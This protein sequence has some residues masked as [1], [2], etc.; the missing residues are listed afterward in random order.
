MPPR[1]ADAST[2]AGAGAALP[3]LPG[4]DGL[5][6]VA[7]VAV[8]LYHAGLSWIPGG[9]LG[10][11]VFFVISGYL[12]TSLLLAEHRR[13]GTVRLTAFW[14]RRARRLLPALFALLAVV[15]LCSLL[16]LPTEVARLRGDVIGALT[17]TANW[18]LV[19]SDQS[20]FETVG[21]PSPLQHLWSLAV[22]EQFYV[23]WPVLFSLGIAYW[24]RA[25]LLRAVAV[26]AVASSA[27]MW[28]LF[29]PGSDPSRAYYGSDTRASGLLVGAVLAFLWTPWRLRDRAGRFAP[30]VIDV[31]GIAALAL[32]VRAFLRT[33]EFDTGLYRGGFLGLGVLTAVL[34]GATVHPA[35][36]VGRLL[37][38]RPLRWVGLRS[39][40]I[41][42]WHWPV[43]V[44]TRPDVD[45]PLRGVPLLALRLAL[46]AVLA[47][48]SYRWV[49]TP[50]RRGA[51]GRYAAAVR[52]ASGAGADGWRCAGPVRSARSCSSRARSASPSRRRRPRPRPSTS[53]SRARRRCS[54]RTGT[55]WSTGCRRAPPRRARP[56]GDRRRRPRLRPRS[57]ARPRSRRSATP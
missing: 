54:T 1:P 24:G 23:V 57:R 15:T 5:R 10:V 16:F 52:E 40:S 55:S 35:G 36:H 46:T 45:V 31:V 12:I 41:Y 26:G 53:R 20:Y 43:Y 44:V 56:A 32:V 30:L 28:L 29:S 8:L 38:V 34:I 13:D 6:A 9:F 11:E 18:H 47:S 39:Y 22:E 37:G 42:L 2:H 3:Y 14:L 48:V 50:V 19:L 49:E 4:L 51:L 33:G 17:Y 25:R 27:V 21:R 7:V